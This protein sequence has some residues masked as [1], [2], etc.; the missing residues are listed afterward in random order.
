MRRLQ[1]FVWGHQVRSAVRAAVLSAALLLPL[2]THAQSY[3]FNIPAQDL[4]SAL[5]EFGLQA[6][7]QV[8]FS[9]EIVAGRR[10]NAVIGNYDPTRALKTLLAGTRLTY[11]VTASNVLLIKQELEKKDA[12]GP[13]AIKKRTKAEAIEV[14]EMVVT[15]R[16]RAELITETPVVITAL[17]GEQ[18]V[19][20]GI[21]SAEALAQLVPNV[22]IHPF[23]TTDLMVMRGVGASGGN[24]GFDPQIGLF[25][26]GVYY[27]NGKWVHSGFFDLDNVQVLKGPQGVYFGKNTIAGAIN[28]ETKGPGKEL[29]GDVKIGYDFYA[30]ERYGEAGVSVPITDKISVRVAGRASQ[31]DGWTNTYGKDEPGSQDLISRMTVAYRPLP[32]LDVTY[33]LQYNKYKDNGGNATRVITDCPGNPA[34]GIPPGKPAPMRNFNATGDAPCERGFDTSSY[35]GKLYNGKESFVRVESWA[36]TLNMH[37]RTPNVGELTSITG[38]NTNDYWSF[39]E[40]GTSN[41]SLLNSKNDKHYRSFSQEGR[42]LSTFDFPVNFLAGMYY[43]YSRFN[44]VYGAN[45]YPIAF[46]KAESTWNKFNEQKGESLAG[47][48]EVQWRIIPSLELDAGVRYTRETKDSTAFNGPNPDLIASIAA[49][50]PP[51]KRFEADQTF[52]N[53]S[54]QVSLTWKPME[55]VMLYTA[56]RSGF[57]SGGFNHSNNLTATT[58]QVDMEFGV[59]KTKG[60]EA[61]AKFSLFDRRVKVNVAGYYYRYDGLQTNVFDPESVSFRIQNA[62]ETEVTGFEINGGLI[63]GYGFNFY[64][65]LS[66]NR[67]RYKEY[68]G[69][70]VPTRLESAVPGQGACNVLLGVDSRGRKVW[71]QD[72]GGTPTDQAPDWAGRVEIDYAHGFETPFAWLPG[73]GHV[74]LSSAVGANWT[75]EYLLTGANT[76]EPSHFLMDARLSLQFGPWTAGVLGRNLS[77][78]VL[79]VYG[80]Q[81]TLS[82]TVP[83]ENQC[84]VGRSREVHLTLAYSF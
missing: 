42:Y 45:I 16:H 37:Y 52:T 36:N 11:E 17:T 55:D 84:T 81:R 75:T 80:G 54:P 48:G 41:A 31:M 7:R 12:P 40:F 68:I 83:A 10:S 27:G 3:R 18:V 67:A 20:K 28:I 4:D 77:N 15:A 23:I 32:E 63:M 49:G 19:E 50:I 71:G 69:P 70:C 14:E 1:P 21:Y 76:D 65:S 9:P 82:S 56:Y 5:R 78:E 62:A 29:E 22:Y 30:K 72:F 60:G 73:S 26:D 66:Y 74:E 57:L 38:F 24:D 47:F 8:L 64:N 59:E 34:L 35:T 46:Q 79:C 33:K 58:R 44:G 25:I 39:G 61:G 51:G 53:T 13:G 43:Q 2:I 6:E